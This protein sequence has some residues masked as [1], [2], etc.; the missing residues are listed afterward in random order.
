MLKNK[1][2]C[3]PTIIDA[4]DRILALDDDKKISLEL[5]LHNIRDTVRIS[6]NFLESLQG[7]WWRSNR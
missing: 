1:S 6:K 4:L 5:L 3:I 7:E 2:N